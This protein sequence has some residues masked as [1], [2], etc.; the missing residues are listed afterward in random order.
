MFQE[1]L[2]YLL[3]VWFLCKKNFGKTQNRHVHFVFDNS[4]VFYNAGK[5]AFRENFPA[6]LLLLRAGNLCGETNLQSNSEWVSTERMA[7]FFWADTLSR[8]LVD[9][10]FE[11]K[12]KQYLPLQLSVRDFGEFTT[13][14]SSE[15]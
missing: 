10:P 1:L 2:G 13:C 8:R 3:A 6:N 14:F 7:E 9:F 5:S 4:A 15:V 11:F 12:G